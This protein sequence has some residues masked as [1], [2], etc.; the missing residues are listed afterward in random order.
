MEKKTERRRL[1]LILIFLVFILSIGIGVY[2][3]YLKGYRYY[4]VYEVEKRTERNAS[5]NARYFEQDGRMIRYNNE[6]VSA[7]GRD[8]RVLWNVGMNYKSPKVV[9][10]GEYIAVAE[11]GGRNLSFMNRKTT[12]VNTVTKEVAGEILDLSIS[13]MGQV[14][15]LMGEKKSNLIQIL[16]PFNRNNPLKAEIKTYYKE[17]GY[18][19][20]LAL[21][22]DGTKLVTE[23]VKEEGA[24]L[25]SVLT[26]YHFGRIG[27]NTNADRIVGIFPYE[28]TLFG[29]LQFVSEKNVVA[30]GDNRILGFTM[31]HEPTLHFEKKL[32]GKVEKVDV[33]GSGMALILSESGKKVKGEE[34]LDEDLVEKPGT[35]LVR[36]NA[37]GSKVFE[38]ELSMKRTGLSYKKGESVVYSDESCLILSPDGTEK[39]KGSFQ[40]NILAIFHT[41]KKDRYFLVSGNHVSTIKLNP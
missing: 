22:P 11:I 36:L 2:F 32:Y 10:G 3:F 6:G 1:P 25:K 7:L 28:G 12:P 4:S 31:K 41:E 29:K 27:E 35:F 8:L 5:S 9:M 26:F 20:T 37:E 14:A 21:S 23:F 39:F 16:E 30:V 17:D 34:Y 40:E 24:D 33:D 38:M 19:L 13:E 15:I 18:G